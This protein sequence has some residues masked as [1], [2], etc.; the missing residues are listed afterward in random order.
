MKDKYS[1][2]IWHKEFFDEMTAIP[3]GIKTITSVLYLKK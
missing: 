2:L 3:M 1:E